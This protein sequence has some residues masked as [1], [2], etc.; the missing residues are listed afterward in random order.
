[1]NH[2]TRSRLVSVLFT[3]IA[4]PSVVM[5]AEEGHGGDAKVNQ[6]SPQ[7]ETDFIKTL[8][9]PAGLEAKVWASGTQIVNPVAIDIDDHNRVYAA[10]TLRFRIH[11]VIDLREHMFL[12]RDDIRVTTTDERRA[13]LEKWKDKYPKDYFTKYSERVRLLEDSTGAGRAD[14]VTV[15]ADGFNDTLDGPAA[16]VLVGD[17]VVY[18]ACAPKVWALHDR[19]GKGVSDQRTVIADGMGVRV[20]ISGH[21]L[22]G[23]VW[24]PDGRVYWSLGDR[25][26][27]TTSKEGVTFAAP[28]SGGVFRCEPDGSHLEQIYAGLRNPQELA[29][30]EW[31]DLFTVD[32]NAD[33]GDKARAV[34]ILEGGTAGW[35]HG[36]QL[37]SNEGFAKAAGLEGRQPNPWL[38]EGMWKTDFAERPTFALPPSG[39]VTSGPSGL[40]FYPGSG[41]DETL[42][43]Q[44]LVC[45]YRAGADS[46]V[47]SFAPVA[48]GA[49]FSITEPKKF[50]WGATITDVCF[51]YDGNLYAANYL[52]GWAMS[53]Q[54]RIFTLS[55]P[56]LRGGAPVK[57]LSAV[58]AAGFTKRQ[59]AELAK[60]LAHRD[61]RVRNRAQSELATRGKDG[62]AALS[63]A[64]TSG[65]SLLAR[66]HGIWGLAQAARREPAVAAKLLPFLTDKEPRVREQAAKWL[67][68]LRYAPA[69]AGLL[70]LLKS[71]DP[72]A[73]SFAAIGLGRLKHAAAL[74]ELIRVLKDNDDKDAWLRSAAVTGLCGVADGAALEP[75]TRDLS[76]RAVR[77]GVL[78]ALRK[79]GDVRVANLLTDSDSLLQLEAIRAVYDTGLE[80]AMPQLIA[81]LDK[82]LDSSLSKPVIQLAYLR[83]INAAHRYGDD[84]A[85][86]KLAEFAAN[87]ERP[88]EARVAA[89]KALDKWQRPLAVDPVVGIYR[90]G[91]RR[92]QLPAA[93]ALKEPIMR[94]VKGGDQQLLGTAVILAQRLGLGLDDQALL[95]ILD[96]AA[97]AED[98]RVTALA[99]LTERKNVGIAERLPRLLA[100]DSGVLRAA[101]FTAQITLDPAGALSAARA[102]LS[103]AG[104]G[105][106]RQVQVTAGR[107]TGAWSEL[108]SGAPVAE[109]N[110]AAGCEVRVIERF[111]KPFKDAGAKGSVLPRLTDGVM[112]ANEDDIKAST[113]FDN[114]ESRFVLDVKQTVEVGRIDT[115]SW[116]KSNRASQNLVLW[117]ADGA[118]MPDANGDLAT[119]GWTR[120]AKIDTGA[121]GEGGKHGSAVANA[122]GALG[123]FRWILWQE[124]QHVAGTFF[125]EVAVYAHGRMPAGLGRVL[126]ART[127]GDWDELA[128]RA[129]AA[130][131]DPGMITGVKATWIDGAGLGK[132]AAP[133]GIKGQELPRLIAAELPQ[134]DD[135]LERNVWF[136]GSEAHILL[137]LQQPVEVAR[138]NTY[139]WHR[140]ERAPQGFTLWG[141]AAATAPAFPTGAGADPQKAG[142]TQIAR[143]DTAGLKE[144]GKH[145][146]SVTAV[147]GSLGRYRFVLM[148]NHKTGTFLSRIDVL[149]A[150]VDLPA[151]AG[152]PNPA[153]TKLKQH[154]LKTLGTMTDAGSTELLA[155]WLDRLLAG[156]LPPQL[157][158]ELTTAAAARK[159]PVVA[160]RLAKWQATFKADDALAPY[161]VSL[162]GG[163]AAKGRELFLF[164]VVQCVKCHSVDKEG[165]NA[166]PDLKGV[167]NRLKPDAL[168]ESLIVPNAVVV[169]G[170]GTATVTL[171]DGTSVTGFL[172]KKADDGAL[173]IRKPDN[174]DAEVPAAKIASFTPPISSMP[175][176]GALLSREDLRDVI[177]YLTSLK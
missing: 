98:V 47:F 1:M 107:T 28:R 115:W 22:H 9:I 48:A 152:A 116:H 76:S 110:L 166:G 19:A 7:S 163:N 43:G 14:K 92:E 72:R 154:V 161:R 4:A 56:K 128:M 135:D 36:W 46:G 172:T 24:G 51:G 120:L 132:P 16:G 171:I 109:L 79:L 69:A 12:Y 148:Q 165:G 108:P 122:N 64:A 6:A 59:V 112:A 77:H 75:F 39:Y 167:G 150:G 62:I 74:P 65:S 103:D 129:P 149:A 40:A 38:E 71:V 97:M 125:S 8:T 131:G 35:D 117:A 141:S 111:A 118:T 33:I 114:G 63:S 49:G 53:D 173:T 57:E 87:V 134:N 177:A 119:S 91:K 94:I 29:F 160:E 25:G 140:Q 27:H 70:A 106:E 99:Q 3:I 147:A 174:T 73:Q 54:G 145:G 158:L 139:S 55:D 155:S 157:M 127:E 142:W 83:L 124:P 42:S 81:R 123:R 86:S 88:T 30:N 26:Y 5:A 126:T 18:L 2:R 151:L 78:L 102:A 138:I 58:M 50:I 41:F 101:A 20:S 90:P 61:Q 156:K 95:T 144:G 153:E 37:L 23:L 146:S 10:E 136:D 176:M 121:H 13:M 17:G 169:P 15:F 170:F 113:W 164:S 130:A 89:L 44:F 45:D 67:G 80:A 85:A 68:D 133:A 93:A 84:A 137:D 105:N 82:P 175:P 104:A 162:S 159:E 100:D 66:V 168:L 11:G 21:D 52:G 96:N 32:N 34:Y 31:G 143:V 60:L